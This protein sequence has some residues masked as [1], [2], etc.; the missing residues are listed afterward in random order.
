MS[1]ETLPQTPEVPEAP[2]GPYVYDYAASPQRQIVMP[3]TVPLPSLRTYQAEVK[4]AA[5]ADEA[6]WQKMLA[7][8]ETA[9]AK[10]EAEGK[11]APKPPVRPVPRKDDND[12]KTPW[13]QEATD[14]DL[15]RLKELLGDKVEEIFEQA[16]ELTC[17]VA[18]EAILEALQL[19]RQDAKL[20]YE[21]LADQTGT[22]YPA[23]KDFAF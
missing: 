21:M 6:K 17:Q 14:P 19:C 12:M 18:K 10:A 8:F 13:P 15:L 7:D 4:A 11:D 2:A 1:D 5:E 22:H 16:G 20:N 9:K 3:K 23:A